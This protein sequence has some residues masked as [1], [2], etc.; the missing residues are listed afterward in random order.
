M[1]ILFDSPESPGGILQYIPESDN[2]RVLFTTRSRAVA[3]D[4]GGDMIKLAEMNVK[5]AES[6]LEK[7]LSGNDLLSDRKRVAELLQELTYLPLA[8]TQAAA[9]IIKNKVSIDEYVELLQ[10]ADQDR[11]GL[12]TRQFHD[13]T[14]YKESRHAVATTWLISLRQ[15]RQSDPDAADLLPFLSCIEPKAIPQSILPPLRSMEAWMSAIGTLDAYAL[16]V[17]RE[18]TT[19]FDIHSLVHLAMKVSVQRGWIAATV[20][21]SAAKVEESAIKHIAGIFPWDNYEWRDRWRAYMPH[22][23]RILR[24]DDTIN[25]VAR[26]D[27]CLKVGNCLRNDD[28]IR[29]AVRYLQ[30]CYDWQKEHLNEDNPYL[31]IT[32]HELARVYQADGQVIK[33]LQLLE[34]VVQIEERTLAEDN[35]FRISSQHGLAAAY[36]ADGQVKKALRLLEKEVQIKE[37]TLAEDDL[38]LLAPQQE[39]AIVYQADGQVNKAL[40]LQEKVV[41]IKERRLA[42]D[43]LSRLR[44]EHSLATIFWN[45]DQHRRA[46]KIMTQVVE[47]HQRVLDDDNTERLASEEWLNLFRDTV[48][49]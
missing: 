1:D 33:A 20:E 36:K 14:R 39:L 25:V 49:S 24:Q 40:Q 3:T 47:I 43:I 32:Q 41:Q 9:Y 11:V 4:V 38:S 18:N 31:L 34:K 37:R 19:M 16:V 2:G 29:D 12:I 13:P 48:N 26:Y 28:R 44:S 45:L 30:D 35:L 17:R 21:E 5:E 6:L 27:L 15:I 10:G 46:L 22:A 42:E 23:L 8:I 7:S